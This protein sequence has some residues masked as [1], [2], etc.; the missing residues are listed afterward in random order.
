DVISRMQLPPFQ[1]RRQ[2]TPGVFFGQLSSLRVPASLTSSPMQRA[3]SL[4]TELP[5]DTTPLDNQVAGHSFEPG[6][7]ALGMLKHSDGTILKPCTKPLC[8]IRESR[9]YESL[10]ESTSRSKALLAS[11]VPEYHGTRRLRV[12]PRDINFIV[13][14]DVTQGMR[15]PC[16]MDVKIGKRTWDPLATPEKIKA[17]ESKYTACKNALSFCIP[18]FQVHSIKTGRVR[19]FGKDYGK[20]LSPES[21]KEALRTFLNA[22]DDTQLCR[23]LLVQLL[24]GLW[25]VLRWARSQTDLRL[26]SSSLLLAYDAKRL[27]EELEAR[28]P[29][30]KPVNRVRLGRSGSLRLHTKPLDTLSMNGSSCALSGQLSPTGAP[31]FRPGRRPSSPEILFSAASNPATAI[32][33]SPTKYRGLQRTHSFRHNYDNDMKNIRRNYE[34]MLDDLIATE[35]APASGTPG[36]NWAVV[37]MIDFAHVFPATNEFGPDKNYLAGVENLVKLFEAL[38]VETEWTE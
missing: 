1:G 25:R 24:A 20:K 6:T 26:Y 11:L 18:G 38:L 7:D 16:I 36:D 22:P 15:E 31:L 5:P 3:D 10:K 17:E 23:A 2:S 19:R 13:L 32:A 27:R 4:T 30:P 21:V 35:D 9:F 28:P 29:V 37:K 8:G 34:S 33:G 12:G 14:A